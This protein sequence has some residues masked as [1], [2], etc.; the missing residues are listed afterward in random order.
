MVS[1]KKSKR[2]GLD[3]PES[4]VLP[5]EDINT[6]QRRITG[7]KFPTVALGVCDKCHWCYTLINEKGAIAVCH[8][9]KGK[10]SRIP[11]SLDEIC[12]IEE[13]KRGLTISFD[14]RLPVQ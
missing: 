14:R 5:Y 8:L 11:M 12:L 1:T 2:T 13:E 10:L 7:E 9:C 4:Q 3:S 6:Q